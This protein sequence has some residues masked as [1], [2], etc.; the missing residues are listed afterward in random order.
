MNAGELRAGDRGADRSQLIAHGRTE[1]IPDVVTPPRKLEILE[2]YET[3]ATKVQTQYERGLIT[4]D[5][6][7]QELI[8]IWT[9]ATNE[10]AKEMESNIPK[11]NTIYRMVSS[12]ARGNWMQPAADR[13]YAWPGVEPE[14]RHHPAPDPRELP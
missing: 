4:D 13:R 2:G 14:G 11:T 9:Q 10:V 3:K 5:E 6:R 1:N 8:E 7:R 12:G